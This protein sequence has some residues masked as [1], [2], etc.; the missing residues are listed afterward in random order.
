MGDLGFE[1]S[2]SVGDLGF[3]V[4]ESVGL[5]KSRVSS[6]ETISPH[7][8]RLLS[9]NYSGTRPSYLTGILSLRLVGLVGASG[10]DWFILTLDAQ[11]N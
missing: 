7:P 2:V 3:E 4:S 6:C 1:V 8:L 11:H 5:I 9:V 10:C